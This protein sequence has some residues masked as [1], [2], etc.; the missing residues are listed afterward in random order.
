MKDRRSNLYI[1]KE[2][3][4]FFYRQYCFDIDNHLSEAI[5]SV[6]VTYKIILHLSVES[7]GKPLRLKKIFVVATAIENVENYLH[8]LNHRGNSQAC[9]STKN[10]ARLAK[11]FPIRDYTI[12]IISPRGKLP[13]ESLLVLYLA[14]TSDR[15]RSLK[16]L[17]EIKG[18]LNCMVLIGT[19]SDTSPTKDSFRFLA[20]ARVNGFSRDRRVRVNARPLLPWE[21]HRASMKPNERSESSTLISGMEMHLRA[22]AITVVCTTYCTSLPTKR[23]LPKRHETTLSPIIAI[24]PFKSLANAC[25][26]LQKRYDD[27]RRNDRIA[28]NEVNGVGTFY[29]FPRSNIRRDNRK[30]D[31]IMACVSLI[32]VVCVP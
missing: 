14:Y 12:S 1:D 3:R 2:A 30:R 6:K 26:R 7:T 19:V 29:E 16:I 28:E 11:G 17:I 22:K 27:C 23:A 4:Y 24:H 8:S 10:Q 31:T 32:I 13:F 5:D 15:K 18:E 20:D 21:I 25:Q 9:F